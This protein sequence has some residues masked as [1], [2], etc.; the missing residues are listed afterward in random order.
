MGII[1][2]ILSSQDEALTTVLTPEM[3]A[4]DVFGL[5]RKNGSSTVFDQMEMPH[6]E[7]VIAI[8]GHLWYNWG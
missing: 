2:L 8:L 7:L 6:L 3:G 1:P 5:G 4:F